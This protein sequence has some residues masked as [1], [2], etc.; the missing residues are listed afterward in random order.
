MKRFWIA[1]AILALLLAGALGQ[2][3]YAARYLEDMAARLEQAQL[4]VEEKED[5][6]QA[7]QMSENVF[8]S[9]EDHG[10]HL[11]VTMNHRDT[12]QIL[13]SIQSLRQYLQLEELDQYVA[14]N[15][16]LAA[17]LRLLVDLEQPTLENIL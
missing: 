13:F 16:Q 12:D 11:H 3:F 2:G 4:L 9:W 10:F 1:C 15:A 5:W 17:Q 6:G 14:A 8:S 7:R